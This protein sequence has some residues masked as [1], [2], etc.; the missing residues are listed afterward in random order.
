[1]LFIKTNKHIFALTNFIVV[2]FLLSY[3]L[4]NS[5]PVSAHTLT[6]TT[7]NSITLPAA[8]TKTGFRFDGWSD[9]TSTYQ[10]GAS[11]TV[12]A[13][14]NFSAVWTQLYTA[15]FVDEDSTSYGSAQYAA[16]DAI[17]YPSVT[18]R[19]GSTYA[20]DP[21][22]ATMPA[23]DT[24]FTLRWTAAGS[25]INF[26]TN[27]GTPVASITGSYGD[28]VSAPADEPTKNGYTFAGWYA[29]SNLT[30][31]YVFTTMP[32]TAI[33]VYAKWTANTYNANF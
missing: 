6:I 26:E 3:V 21:N 14:T 25:S 11:Y 8:Q 32:A 7:N 9:G 19:E 15:T 30:T 17:V 12:S 24:T 33:T 22:P 2:G 10:P 4:L 18:A 20:W 31:P 1:M 23:A 28:A 13:D 5:S 29:D 16:G 27:G